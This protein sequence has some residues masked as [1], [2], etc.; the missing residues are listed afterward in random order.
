MSRG[1]WVVF[2]SLAA[3]LFLSCWDDSHWSS[4]DGGDT[5]TDVDTD[6][7]S[8]TDTDTDTDT[9]PV[10]TCP[11][12]VIGEGGSDSTSGSTWDEGL[13]SVERGLD[14]AEPLGCDVWVKAGTYYPTHDP[15]GSAT[16]D[17]PRTVTFRLRAGVAL[18]GGFAG[19]EATLEERDFV[20]N[21]TILSGDI[22]AADDIS[23]N[24][25]HVVTGTDGATIDGFT[26]TEGNADNP[27]NTTGYGGGM[28]NDFFSPIVVNCVFS[29][30]YA[31]FGAGMLNACSSPTVTSCT[32]SN[33]TAAVDGAGMY[34]MVA[35]SPTVVDCIFSGNASLSL[36]DGTL[37]GGGMTNH[38][39]SPTV[40]NCTFF[41]NAGEDAGGMENTDYSSPMVVNSVF[42][43][44][45]GQ[46]GGGMS[47]RFN[48]SPTITNCT[49]SSNNAESDWG[50]G[51]YNDYSDAVITN[52]ILWGD[53][54]PE[55]LNFGMYSFS[56]VTYSD[57][58]GGCS[59]VSGCTTDE[60][61]NIDSD[62]F[63][64]S[65]NDL[66]LMAGSPCI[67]AANGDA[68]PEFDIEGNPRVDNPAT[69]NTGVGAIDFADMG[70]FEHQL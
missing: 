42:L 48:S 53:S 9:S 36:D 59:V 35:S 44:N 45:S 30:N 65:I 20:A 22:G 33:N 6:T 69:L 32:F 47:N 62:P 40:R 18:Y 63:F 28:I 37:S 27:G 8:D 66:H 57:V 21:V 16:P 50:G 24:C 1:A 38:S 17:D 41:A 31:N 34:N 58:Q 70:S 7:D 60:I 23:D 4:P 26:I 2:L 51:I 64:V 39:S 12:H 68:A 29:G 54:E 11:V 19:D 14:L 67:D 61:G 49:F 25:Y 13:A 5:D 3:G 56:T 55:I 43:A 10:T 52:C 46:T 15:D